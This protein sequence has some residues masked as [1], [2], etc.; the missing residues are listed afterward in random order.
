[1]KKQAEGHTHLSNFCICI[2]ELGTQLEPIQKLMYIDI[3]STYMYDYAIC[4]NVDSMNA[5]KGKTHLKHNHYEQ[6]P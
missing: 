3:W 4:P 5:G 6:N 1:M 2:E